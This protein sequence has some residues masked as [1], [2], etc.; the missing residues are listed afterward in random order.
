LAGAAGTT[1]LNAHAN[2][3]PSTRWTRPPRCSVMLER[4][5]DLD[6]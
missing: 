3:S 1:A 6:V 5:F 4:E 2:G